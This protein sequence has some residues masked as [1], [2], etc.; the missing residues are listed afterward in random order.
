M[1]YADHW[2]RALAKSALFAGVLFVACLPAAYA[3]EVAVAQVDGHVTDPS[4]ASIASATVKM[5]EV[6]RRTVHQAVTDATGHF[7]LPNLPS[8]GYVLEVD[9]PGFKSYRQTGITL[10]IATNIT[11]PVQMQIGAV[12][13]TV[14]V[15]A[16]ASMVETKD[17]A[18]AQVT[19]Q[20]RI[21]ELP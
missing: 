6:E 7:E 5:T 20:Q 11:I 10:Q 15:S 13:E 3:Q 17:N 14:E 9:A 2:S 16:N 8:G 12:S 21:V 19:D 18:I 4:G 1:I